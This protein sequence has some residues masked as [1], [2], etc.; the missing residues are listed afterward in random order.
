MKLYPVFFLLFVS[1]FSAQK[2]LAK[3]C[4]MRNSSG[5]VVQR[6]HDLLF[7]L[8][9]AGAVCPQN[10]IEVRGLLKS[11]GKP[12][13]S[14]MVANRGFHNPSAGSFSLFEVLGQAEIFFGHFT[15]LGTKNTLELDQRPKQRSLMAEFM[16]WDP[17]TEV[18]NFYELVGSASGP[19]W[20]YRG[21]ST[22]IW[23]DTD[24]LHRAGSEPSFGSRLRCSGCHVMGG[25]IMKE[26]EEP[27]DSWWRKA[28]PLPLAGKIPATAL[29]NIMQNLQEPGVLRSQVLV[30]V[31][32]LM[33]GAAFKKLQM[34]SPQIALRPLFCPMDVNLQAAPAPFEADKPVLVPSAFFI[35][36][37]LLA[38]RELRLSK[39]LYVTALEQLGSSFPETDLLDADHPWN[40]PVKALSDKMAIDVLIARGMVSL[41]FVQKIL[42]YDLT[43]P[44]FSQARCQLMQH[45]PAE[46]S[47]DWER[48]F[49]QK[50]APVKLPAFD[51]KDGERFLARCLDNLKT[52]QGALALLRY[53]GQSR[54]EIEASEIS[55]NPLGAILEPGF[56]VIFPNF[57]ETFAPWSTTLKDDC[58]PEILF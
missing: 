57:N 29:S 21:D 15:A 31:K 50:L 58:L 4:T 52:R 8:I 5:E 43:R 18:Y 38:G 12:L 46:W 24:K 37:R 27:H 49:W 53:L 20:F 19:I 56:R 30:G 13:A 33:A 55:Q 41:S 39:D 23:R 36:D 16:A 11:T 9:T 3:N 14:T 17:S 35:D 48:K 45:L 26:I 40:A 6:K 51:V 28:R 7:S 54:L 44:V 42:A 32:K 47:M 2:G 34:S 1:A 25:P 22:D 10:I